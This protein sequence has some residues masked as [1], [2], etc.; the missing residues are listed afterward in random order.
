MSI[1][2]VDLKLVLPFEIPFLRQGFFSG[3]WLA[4]PSDSYVVV[5][6]HPP[7]GA[8]SRPIKGQPPLG[9]R[10]GSVNEV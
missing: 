10:Q 6:P 2:M 1:C 5:W 8:G 3:P 9:A 7:A 4:H